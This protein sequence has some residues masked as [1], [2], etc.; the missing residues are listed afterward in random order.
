MLA[1]GYLMPGT[2]IADHEHWDDDDD[3]QRM[4]Y[5]FGHKLKQVTDHEPLLWFLCD[6][7]D[8]R[9]KDVEMAEE[10]EIQILAF[11]NHAIEMHDMIV[12]C[13]GDDYW[14]EHLFDD[15]EE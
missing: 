11:L 1:R 5:T 6:L 7:F 14:S 12:K 3:L 10:V 4:L 9:G 2:A 13:Y 15:D 8:R